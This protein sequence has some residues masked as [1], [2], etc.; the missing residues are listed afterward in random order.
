MNAR[1]ASA[2]LENHWID[3][4]GGITPEDVVAWLGAVQAQDSRAALWAI[5]LRLPHTAT[6]AMVQQALDDGRILRTHVLRPTWHFVTAGDIRW[7]L[8]LTAPH[9]QRRA[10]TYY[11]HLGLD[12]SVRRRG[13]RVIEQALASGE[14][15]TR[16][17]LGSALARARLPLTGVRLAMMTVHTE[18]EGIVCSGRH[19]GVH[20]TYALLSERARPAAPFSRDEA[21]AELSRRYLRSHAPVTI[22]DFV[23]WSGLSSADA[24]RGF[25][26]V[27][28][29]QERIADHVYWSLDDS[30]QGKS[31]NRQIAPSSNS[32]R[33]RSTRVHLLPFYDEYLVAYRDLHAVPRP[34]STWGVLPQAV[35]AKGQVAGTWKVVR[36]RDSVTIQITHGRAMSR[37]EKGS[38][39]RAAERYS[40]FFEL[41]MCELAND[42]L[43]S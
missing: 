9:V 20:P 18:L 22:R 35:I 1:V 15:R 19:R 12:Q 14:H 17:E 2:R 41:G 33:L 29:R 6:A 28:A 38:L 36:Q 7:M 16:A 8:A 21:L 32:T 25:A 37:S 27:A 43:G 39:S 10:A 31:S 11:R 26:A 30:T 13:A 24:R 3:S 4:P 42:E 34:P 40:R 5:G 23:W